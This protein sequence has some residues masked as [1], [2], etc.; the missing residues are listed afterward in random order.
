MPPDVNSSGISFS[1]DSGSI[2]FGLGAIKG[3][4]EGAAA[5]IIAS[6]EQDGPFKSFLD[7]CERCG[8]ELNS[9]MVE[10]LTRAGALDALKLRRS[11]IMA[12]AEQ[13]MSYAAGRAR[14]K[15]MGQG[16]LF[17]LLGGGDG[18]AEG[19]DIPIPD[20]PEFDWDEIL[21]SEKEL[22]GFYVSGH[23]LDADAEIL[24]DYAT[25]LRELE[26]LA[27]NA[28]VRLAGMVSSMDYRFGKKSGKQFGVLMLE[29]I[30]ASCELMLY[31]RAL[32]QVTRDEIPLEPGTPLCIEATVSRREA[33][34]KPR[35]M[36]DR[37]HR[38]DY[39]PENFTDELYLHIYLDRHGRE[40]WEKA[41]KLCLARPGD[42]RLF[43]CFVDKG[44][45]V[46][47]LESRRRISVTGTLLKQLDE[48]LGNNCYRVRAKELE[49]R[50]RWVPPQQNETVVIDN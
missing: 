18:E 12:T 9:R 32:G 21:K 2:R 26:E 23:P 50:R 40:A 16:S 33:G 45:N 3:V 13:M 30:D 41:A 42:V 27:D 47:Y 34:E 17:D 19:C 38:L 6:R 25:P 4:G 8:T 11:Q 46:T 31:E 28:P 29:D 20:I 49:Q 5:K 22:L 43:V 1:V 24:R 48:V 15:A 44:D 37:I 10:F 39:A 35:I 14:D 7:F 36:V